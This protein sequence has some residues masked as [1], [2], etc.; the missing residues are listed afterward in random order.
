MT[1]VKV[2]RNQLNEAKRRY[3]ALK[4]TFSAGPGGQ[5]IPTPAGKAFDAAINSMR[6]S[7][8]ALT[9]VP[10]VG[11]MSDYETRLDQS[12]FPDRGQYEEVGAQ[13]LAAL[14]QLL[15]TIEQGYSEI[16]GGRAPAPA[17]QEAPKRRRFNPE[18]GKI[19]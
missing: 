9:R 2:A 4:D 18:T 7:I 1:Q 3:E 12:K 6:G 17:P 15:D 16:L 8:T 11:A 14:E 10:G 5:F 13:Q 19:E